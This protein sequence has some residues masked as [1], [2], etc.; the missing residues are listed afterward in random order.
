MH[1][2]SSNKAKEN[3]D[4][5]KHVIR[6]VFHVNEETRPSPS[7]QELILLIYVK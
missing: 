2:H 6:I 1:K 7:I 4:Q 3:I 5:A